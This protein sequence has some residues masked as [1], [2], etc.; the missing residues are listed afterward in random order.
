MINVLLVED[1]ATFSAIIESFLKK[2][3]YQVEPYFSISNSIS[4]I[5]KNKYDL[6]LLDYRLGDGNGLEVLD[7]I[8]AQGLLIPVIIMTGFS[9]VRTAVRAMRKGVYDYITKPVNPDELLMVIK[10]ALTNSI[11]KPAS[12][13]KSKRLPEDHSDEKGYVKGKSK[14][15]NKLHEYIELV[16]PT[17]M[18]VLIRGE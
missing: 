18:T 11:E 3:G 16:A 13:L 1:D 14:I 10:E 12:A 5:K 4:A 8:H 15:A 9:D 7:F 2:N 17:D 6:I